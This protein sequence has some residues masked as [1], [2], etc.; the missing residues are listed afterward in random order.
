LE[1]LGR[2]VSR[3]LQRRAIAEDQRN[4]TPQLCVRA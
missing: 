1:T 4:A 3:L 2:H